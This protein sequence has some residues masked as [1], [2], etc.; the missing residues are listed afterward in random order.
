M[1]EGLPQQPY[2]LRALYEWCVDSGYTPHISVR[3]DGRCKVPAAFVRDGEIVLNVGP[4]A[5]RNLNIDNEL[6]AFSARFSGVAQE[7]HVPID[8]VLAIYARETGEGMA[9]Q[10]NIM[11]EVPA[12]PRETLQED[13]P[14][15]PHSPPPPPKGR[16]ALKVV[17]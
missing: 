3:V 2:F 5:V 12:M 17:K 15:E 7:V 14:A 8:A 1:S 13:V 4:N 6:V 10:K 16:P 9:F 11:A